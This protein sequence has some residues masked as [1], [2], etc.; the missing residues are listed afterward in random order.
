MALSDLL[1]A[2]FRGVPFAVLRSGGQF[3]R[4]VAVHQYPGRDTPW[5]EDL[6]RG[7]RR[8]RITGFLLEGDLI[9]GGGPID[10]QRDLLIAAAEGAGASLLTHPTLGILNVL[11]ESLSLD[12]G[13]EAD[14]YAG[15]EFSFVEA[16]QQIFP[17]LLI[18]TGD[19][20]VSAVMTAGLTIAADIG[21]ALAVA[22]ASSDSGAQ[23]TAAAAKTWSAQVEALGRDAT[24]VLGLSSQL[25]GSYGRYSAG[26]NAGFASGTTYVTSA[27]V[28]DLVA[29]ASAA[30]ANVSSA[31]DALNAA[32]ASE[33][34]T[35]TTTDIA[36]AVQALVNALLSACADPADAIRL[37]LALRTYAPI[38]ATAVDAVMQS[39][40]RRAAVTAAAQASSTYQPSSYDDASST[41]A[42]V[43]AALDVEIGAA[44]DVGD[45][46]SFSTLRTIRAA[47]VQDLTTR[48]ASLSPIKT[49]SLGAS[50]PDVVLAQRLYRDP[51]RAGQL[52]TQ[53]AEAHPLFMPSEFDALAA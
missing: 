35:T 22:Q 23:D 12:D 14:N 53:V 28:A 33:N 30:R 46:G 49:F 9:Y 27:T 34:S 32:V 18:A 41:L 16:G 19:A 3:G 45:D 11:C 20:V 48:G 8:I 37:L 50:V 1:P 25:S 51:S 24:A 29:A 13:I 2:S 39:A 26:A 4:R 31:A 21:S 44:G 10:L 36:T 15:F 38:A 43:T 7:A 42:S 52:T 47:V 5:A 40:F 17:S 6:G